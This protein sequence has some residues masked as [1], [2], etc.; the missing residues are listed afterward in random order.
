MG[1]WSE[2]YK[3]G[4]FLPESEGVFTYYR[5]FLESGERR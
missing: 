4:R 2:F 1:K 3:G 5:C